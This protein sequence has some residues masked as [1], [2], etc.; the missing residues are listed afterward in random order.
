MIQDVFLR[1]IV[2]ALFVLSAA[3]C[4]FAIATGRLTWTQIVSRLLHFIMSVAMVAMAWPWGAALPTTGPMVFFLLAA[5]WFVAVGLAGVG[6]RILNGYHA[7][8]MLAMAWMYAVMNGRLL[9][10]QGGTAHGAHNVTSPATGMPDM[11]MPGMDMPD[12]ATS[13]SGGGYP[14]WIGAIIWA[15]T[16]G[17]A[18]A[19]LWWLYRF[20]ALRN[21]ASKQPSYR[22]L[23]IA[24]QAMMAAGMAIMFGVIL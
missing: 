7:L 9:P 16:I 19:A 18:I 17:F 13:S 23:W 14:V 24:R 21:A 1:W 2:T 15:D 5:V 4:V 10:G 6:H 8:M 12:M 11:D 3:E 20:F 22:F